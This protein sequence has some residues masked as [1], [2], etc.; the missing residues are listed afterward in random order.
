MY[1]SFKQDKKIKK[2]TFKNQLVSKY[3]IEDENKDFKQKSNYSKPRQG[4]Y[5][6]PIRDKN[7][8][9]VGSEAVRKGMWKV[10][11]ETGEKVITKIASTEKTKAKINGTEDLDLHEQTAVLATAALPVGT[12]TSSICLPMKNLIGVDG[13]FLEEKRFYFSFL[14]RRMRY[15]DL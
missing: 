11:P 10:D 15:L 14:L 2:N 3:Q 1:K 5:N 12:I 7:G 4:V 9:I 6:I 8:E 13:C